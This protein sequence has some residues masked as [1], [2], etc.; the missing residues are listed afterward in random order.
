[1]FVNK[2]HSLPGRGEMLENSLVWFTSCSHKRK[3]KINPTVCN[4]GVFFSWNR[5]LDNLTPSLLNQVN[6]KYQLL[7]FLDFVSMA[8]PFVSITFSYLFSLFIWTFHTKMIVI[9]MANIHSTLYDNRSSLGI[10][11]T[12]VLNTT[13]VYE[14]NIKAKRRWDPKVVFSNKLFPVFVALLHLELHFPSLYTTLLISNFILPKH[15]RPRNK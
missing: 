15:S 6:L 13:Y 3:I 7:Y 9:I 2:T 1:M 5:C 10:I 11:F 8:Y 4:C 14:H 12:S